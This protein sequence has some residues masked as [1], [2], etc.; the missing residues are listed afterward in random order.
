[1]Y[2][3]Y[4][5]LGKKKG[6]RVRN[7]RVTRHDECRESKESLFTERERKRAGYCPLRRMHCRIKG[8]CERANGGGER[9]NALA[10]LS[11]SSN[12]FFPPTRTQIFLPLASSIYNP[13][14]RIALTV[15]SQMKALFRRIDKIN[16]VPRTIVE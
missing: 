2:K 6:T 7:G 13:S 5:G 4:R 15:A 10:P 12:F 14:A 11:L 16:R 9:N 1:M 3:Y 8:F